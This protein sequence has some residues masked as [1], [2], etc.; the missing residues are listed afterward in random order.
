MFTGQKFKYYCESLAM[1]HI[2]TPIYNLRSSGQAE[3]FTDTFKRALQKNNNINTEEKSIKKFLTIYRI[4]PNQ[5]TNANLSPAE[6][7]FARKVCSVFDR[8]IPRKTEKHY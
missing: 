6:I 1:E 3:R 2:T 4:M 5:N 7:M 8:L